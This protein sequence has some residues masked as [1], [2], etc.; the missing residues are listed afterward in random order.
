[1]DCACFARVAELHHCTSLQW[2][3]SQWQNPVMAASTPTNQSTRSHA[4]RHGFCQHQ[5]G[6]TDHHT[7]GGLAKGVGVSY[8]W[9][10]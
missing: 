4:L 8:G 2:V 7:V 6:A 10:F 9:K 1:M 5:P 3:L